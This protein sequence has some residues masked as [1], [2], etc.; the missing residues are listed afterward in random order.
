MGVKT[1]SCDSSLWTELFISQTWTKTKR[2]TS[3]RDTQESAC[4]S[5]EM[6]VR[7]SLL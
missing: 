3:A 1:Q 6:G 4:K 5:P 7:G 2:D